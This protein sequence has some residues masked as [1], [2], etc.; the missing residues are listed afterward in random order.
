MAY[1]KEEVDGV[2]VCSVQFPC[3]GPFFSSSCPKSF[4]RAL[5]VFVLFSR[6]REIM[7]TTSISSSS[8]LLVPPLLP[9]V[10]PPACLVYFLLK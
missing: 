8:I 3:T 9:S 5:S 10:Q 6:R 1:A 2:L 7:D 4:T